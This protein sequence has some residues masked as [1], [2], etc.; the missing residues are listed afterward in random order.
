MGA[1][2]EKDGAE[3]RQ[4]GHRRQP[5]DSSLYSLRREA[6]GGRREMPSQEL[7]SGRGFFCVWKALNHVYGLRG[8][9][10]G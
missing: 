9:A 7:A 10:A 5:A 1:V 3:E 4:E 8:P 2:K 6:G